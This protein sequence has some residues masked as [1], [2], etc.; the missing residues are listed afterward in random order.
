[1]QDKFNN[2]HAVGHT[3]YLTVLNKD[4]NKI[5]TFCPA[6]DFISYS[7]HS[8]KNGSVTRLFTRN[9]FKKSY[10]IIEYSKINNLKQFLELK[11]VTTM[12]DECNPVG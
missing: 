9:W 7:Q 1:M 4:T 2:K 6:S 11:G 5:L 12:G 3:Y 8:C 10:E